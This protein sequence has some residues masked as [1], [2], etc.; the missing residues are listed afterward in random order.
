[1]KL[2]RILPLITLAL[3]F[4]ACETI[5]DVDIPDEPPRLVANA[6]LQA[7][8]MVVV[9][10]TQSQSILVN[11]D[12]KSVRGATVSL[13]EEAQPVA[14]LEESEAPG[15]Y[16]STFA[17]SVGRTYT[18]RVSKDGFEP[19]EATTFIAPP[20]T[21][22]SVEVD[23]SVFINSY[24]NFEDSLITERNVTL[25][26][27][28]LSFDDPASERNYYEISAYR[29]DLQI[30]SRYDSEGNLI[31]TDTVRYFRP[32]YLRSDD[33]A[34]SGGESDPLEGESDFYGIALLFNDDFFNG[35]Q[36]SLRFSE[37]QGFGFSSGYEPQLY[38]VLRTIDEAQY[39]YLRSVDLQYENEDNPFAEPVQV[40][41]NVENG[42]GIVAGSS[43]SQVVVDLE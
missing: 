41:S 39:R 20:V 14:T 37:A 33:P 29:Y 24:V 43:A 31:D 34:I 40:Y 4:S 5:V 18:L 8:S 30:Q 9:E 7:D 2:I 25:D 32:L 11:S 38:V 15:I 6:F 26:E 36:Y 21:I 3:S 16:F 1:M 35:K 28:R 23:T 12:L 22:R 27:I 17:P 10:L 13:L 42:F 19:V